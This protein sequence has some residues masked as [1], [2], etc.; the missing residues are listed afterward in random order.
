MPDD[1]PQ[2][3][4]DD[5]DVSLVSRSP[6][7]TPD[8]MDVDN[9]DVHK[10][11]E[12]IRKAPREVV[13]VDTKI[14]PTNKGFAMLA[15]LGW[16]EGQPLGLSKEGRVDPIPFHVKQDSTGLGK[17]SQDVR[18]IETT[19]AQRRG[20]DSE[21]QQKE[22]EEQ[23]RAREDLVARKAALESEISS[24]LR[25]FYCTLCDKQFKTVA[26]YD[27]HTNSYAH[28]HRARF[29][30]MQ[31]NIRL[32]PKEEI[33]KRKEKERKREEKEL[34]KMAAAN[35]IRMP[36]PITASSMGSSSTNPEAEPPKPVPVPSTS[37]GAGGFKKSGWATIGV[38]SAPPLPQPQPP[39][40]SSVAPPA[41]APSVESSLPP[42]AATIS[43]RAPPAFR[44]GGWTVL[45]TGSHN[46][47]APASQPPAPISGSAPVGRP[48]P[49]AGWTKITPTDA[50][51]SVSL[52]NNPAPPQSA[53][54]RTGWQQ[55]QKANSRR[56]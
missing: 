41:P 53:P 27:E 43:T 2:D 54:I 39:P 56:K 48:A 26:Q 36:K 34:R 42:P 50:T 32:K 15:K 8:H 40:P 28:H 45:D 13:T 21:R 31:A 1:K 30:D 12:Y 49:G 16:V 9:A 29:K 6:S 14:K 46:T 24:T 7:P 22:T 5:D 47:S 20:L 33:D 23:R 37:G 11:D 55:F 35:G 38:A 51:N 4:D 25:A 10:Y 44:A 18:M 17:I 52:Q 19:V 3:D